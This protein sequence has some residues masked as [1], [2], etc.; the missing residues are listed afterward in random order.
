MFFDNNTINN[1]VID[2]VVWDGK[3]VWVATMKAGLWV[4]DAAGKLLRKITAAD[5]LP[6]ADK[7]M[8]LQVLASGKVI[9]IGSF[10]W[11][12]RGWCATVA[13]NAGTGGKPTIHVFHEA[14]RVPL[15]E[16]RKKLQVFGRDPSAVFAPRWLCALPLGKAGGP[17]LLV[18]RDDMDRLAYYEPLIIDLATLHVD[19]LHLNF[20]YTRYYHPHFAYYYQNDNLIGLGPGWRPVIFDLKCIDTDNQNPYRYIQV[21]NAAADYAKTPDSEVMAGS[22]DVEFMLSSGNWLY[23]PGKQWWRIDMETL[24]GQRL[25]KGKLPDPYVNLRAFGV[26]ALLGLIAWDQYH[27]YRVTIDETKIPKAGE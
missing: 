12:S 8:L 3:V 19:V 17:V 5:G 7:G 1:P 22:L 13:W 23:I 2:D 18:G 27:F 14:K 15:P 16:E 21:T 24:T 26:S 6:P 11:E 25:N 4:F 10:G 9:A 20:G